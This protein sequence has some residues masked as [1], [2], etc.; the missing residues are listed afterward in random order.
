MVKNDALFSYV[1]PGNLFA[2]LL[3]PLRYFMPVDQY[4]WLNR[5]V[6]KVT[7]FPLLFCIY[8]Y[9]KYILAADMYEATDLVDKPRHDRASTVHDL[10]SRSAFFSPSIR[11]RED[12][13]F[14]YQKDR[15]LDEVFRRAPDVRTQR[16]NERRKTQN[17]AIRTWMDQQEAG[18]YASPHRNYSTMDR[19]V[20][21]GWER[22]FSMSRERPSRMHRIYSD[23]RS[24]ASDP[25]EFISDAPY[26]TASEVSKEDGSAARR[27]Y[28]TDTKEVT[29]G[30]ADGDDELVTNDEDEEDMV[31]TNNNDE[32]GTAQEHAVETES[33]YFTTPVNQRSGNLEPSSLDSPRP[34]TSRRVP[35]HTRT[36]SS[37]TILFMGEED[38][39]QQQQEHSDSS[40]SGWP[41]PP[42]RPV[43]RPMRSNTLGDGRRSPRRALYLSQQRPRSMVY[44]GSSGPVFDLSRTAP[45]RPGLTLDTNITNITSPSYYP[46]TAHYSSRHGHYDYHS[47]HARP[48]PRRKSLADLIPSPESV[49]HAPL[50]NV[51]SDYTNA[52]SGGSGGS[53][54]M[55]SKMMWAKMKSLEASLGGIAREMRSL[56]KSVPNTAHNS[57]EEEDGLR[58][59]AFIDEEELEEGLVA[60]GGS[61]GGSVSGS[62]GDRRRRYHWRHQQY[63]QERQQQQQ[64]QR[65]PFPGSDPS[66]TAS[67]VGGSGAF[68][69]VAREKDRDRERMGGLRRSR[70]LPKRI[71]HHH[72]SSQYLSQ[73]QQ[74]QQQAGPC[75][76]SA[77]GVSSGRRSS[78]FRSP[79][80]AAGS[81]TTTPS[82]A[83]NTAAASGLGIAASSSSRKGKEK[84]VG[85]PDPVDEM[86][87]LLPPPA[88]AT[89]TEDES[90]DVSEG[91]AV[92]PGDTSMLG[93]SARGKRTRRRRRGSVASL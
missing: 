27:D 39:K 29:D 2:W 64:Q 55:S 84:E 36:L 37:N 60:G 89:T 41:A 3:M 11:V 91:H 12:S 46:Y 93:S 17:N 53:R 83:I 74:Q 40:A 22:R 77:T 21:T 80:S 43:N 87:P 52:G 26:P 67:V 42:S 7:H 23:M 75:P 33:E 38:V 32:T 63:H 90:E 18:G 31:T 28:A 57:G 20:S 66:S 78:V 85:G 35:L 73:Q 6:I 1:A 54:G 76:S 45:N 44:T 65:L 9:E 81:S 51:P 92:S 50:G 14:G 59:G 72:T 48:L 58:R 69:E 15:V 13:V 79:R 70:T 88:M 8:F 82:T 10:V 4:V 19:V 16:R 71:H 34:P 61:G 49:I 62:G 25:A 86:A 24:A 56:R 5:M 47:Y 30:D 68:I